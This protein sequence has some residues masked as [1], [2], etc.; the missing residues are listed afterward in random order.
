MV[1]RIVPQSTSA[2]YAIFLPV[3]NGEKY[4]SI[5]IHSILAQKMGNF[6]LV[7]LE[8]GSTD[9][10]VDIISGF[11]DPRILLLKSTKNLGIEAN[12]GRI[13]NILENK[14]IEADYCTTIG[15]DDLLYPEFLLSIDKLI[16]EHPNAGLYQTHFDIIDETGQVIRPCMP[17]PFEECCR[18]FFLA[19][20][21]GI[22]DSFGTGYV[23]RVSSY[24]EMQGIPN[25]P[26]LLWSDDLM[27]MRLIKSSSK[28]ASSEIGFAYRLHTRSISGAI[29]VAK[30]GSA[31]KALEH[32][33]RI[34]SEEFH[35]LLKDKYANTSLVNLIRTH[36]GLLD[37]LLAK[38]IYS[39]SIYEKLLMLKTIAQSNARS[40]NITSKQLAINYVGK[41][42]CFF[43]LVVKY[44][45]AKFY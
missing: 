11:D 30:L 2:K 38:L 21:W 12:W 3:R 31:I 19:R 8:N 10:T 27:V 32:F 41:I 25:L 45:T 40:D 13:Y 44:F 29:T 20:C 26:L 6:V 36:L 4:I 18:E 24:I 23:F 35:S 1:E 43:I 16:M 15:H 17:I 42:K 37:I 22:R 9:N 28:M 7:I 5:A 39:K 14:I 33:V 34:I